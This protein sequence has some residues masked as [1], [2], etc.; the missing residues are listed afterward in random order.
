MLVLCTTP[1]V[2]QYAET[3]KEASASI[4]LR[5]TI[6]QVQM[7]PGEPSQSH[8]MQYWPMVIGVRTTSHIVVLQASVW[9]EN[10]ETVIKASIEHVYTP[11]KFLHSCRPINMAI[12]PFC[13][14]EYAMMADN[15]YLALINW[16]R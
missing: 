9:R 14:Q 16:D 1:L 4:D 11:A 3:V 6:L 13:R 5:D 12:N 7:V 2:R 15:G 8:V 10:R